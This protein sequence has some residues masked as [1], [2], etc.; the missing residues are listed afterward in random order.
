MKKTRKIIFLVFMAITVIAMFLPIASFNDNSSAS[1]A[2]DIEKQQG[3]VDSAQSQLDRWIAG[4]K[5][6]EADIQ[7]QRDKVTKEQEKLNELVAQ[8]A[9]ASNAS[10]SGLSYSLLPGKLP[11][12]L[13][14]DMQVV[15]QYKTYQWNFDAYYICIWAAFG[16][17]VLAVGLVLLARDQLVSKLYTFSAF[18]HLIGIILI[19]YVLLRL[20]AFPI[21]LPYGN[22]S[23]HTVTAVALILCP[24]VAFA[25]HITGI[26]NSK[27]SMI[28][29]FCSFLSVLAI[30]P[31]WIMIVNA[32]RS[33]QAIQ[34]GVSLIPG[35]YLQYNWNVLSS[36]NFDVSVG[37]MN[38]AIIAFGSTIL[39]VYFS[40]MTAY[41]CTNIEWVHKSR[42]T[43]FG[44][45]KMACSGLAAGLGADFFADKIR[46][47]L[48]HKAGGSEFPSGDGYESRDP[49]S[50]LM[51]EQDYAATDITSVSGRISNHQRAYAG[52]GT[53]D[54]G[55]G[56]ARDQLLAFAQ[57]Q[58]YLLRCGMHI[59]A[60]LDRNFVRCR[61]KD[62][63]NISWN[64]YISVGRLAATVYDMPR[65]PVSEDNQGAFAGHHAYVYA[66][67]AGKPRCPYACRQ[68]DFPRPEDLSLRRTDTDYTAV[69]LYQAG[70][71]GKFQDVRPVAS[72][73]QDIGIHQTERIHGCIRHFDSPDYPGIDRRLHPQ[74]LGRIDCLGVDSGFAAFLNEVRL[75]VQT[76]FGK[77]NEKPFG[78]L[79]AVGSYPAQD[80][81][82]T[83]AFLGTFPVGNSIACSAVKQTV[84][85]AGRTVADVSP[86]Y[87]K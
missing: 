87:Q 33:S 29:V 12:E 20:T 35:T 76:V 30:V 6:S 48:R 79:Y 32:T 47:H 8:Q 56:K 67:F 2:A 72:G 60:C 4:G 22:A 51:V 55:M 70:D 77:R 81:V 1:I 24:L 34:Q 10:G 49:V 58:F 25:T 71:S 73:V 54:S 7:K 18:L 65:D 26:Q 84:I 46:R 57:Q 23:I 69:L 66:C 83:Y 42:P 37:F 68:N 36:K 74:R 63:D 43:A 15:N 19:C 41:G 50:C 61:A 59:V 27:R 5:K 16:C 40:A 44:T 86:L 82:F 3:K 78:R 38:S 17:F 80:A 75:I 14:I 85:P 64:K 28:Y 31:F 39:S 62:A 45:R 53:Y 9:A 13:E 52:V 11:A 21:K